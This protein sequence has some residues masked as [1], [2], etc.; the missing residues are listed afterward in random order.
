[1]EERSTLWPNIFEPTVKFW[2]P[3][4]PSF[5]HLI[6]IDFVLKRMHF[7]EA[8]CLEEQLRK[9]C[10]ESYE[11]QSLKTRISRLRLLKRSPPKEKEQ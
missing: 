8:T 1:M 9:F 6:E 11:T 3:Q 2:D 5:Y 4:L 10:Q 7:A